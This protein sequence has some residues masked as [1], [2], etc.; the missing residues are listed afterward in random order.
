MKKILIFLILST[1]ISALLFMYLFSGKPRDL[2]VK[3]TP[4]DYQTADEKF[5][6][7]I[8]TIESAASVKD[9]LVYSGKKDINLALNSSQITA[10]AA[11]ETWKY[12]PI[13]D[14]QIKINPD[15]TGE[16]SGRLNVENVLSYVSLVTPIDEVQK[17]INKFKIPATPIFYTK[18]T[19]SVTDNKVNFSLQSFEVAH[20]PVPQNYVSENTGALNNFV[21]DRLNS[22]PDLYIRSLTLDNAQANIDATIPEKVLKVEK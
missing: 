6:V 11:A 9:S 17:A 12:S 22:I 7:E 5:G 3:F 16:V 8:G 4:A 19:V 18:G 2:G 14:L 20:I 1:I 15:G 21:T 10:Y 13:S